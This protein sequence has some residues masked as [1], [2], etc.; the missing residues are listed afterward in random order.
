MNC[1]K[2]NCL[3]NFVENKVNDSLASVCVKVNLILFKV[4]NPFLATIAAKRFDT[5]I[6]FRRTNENTQVQNL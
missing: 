6:H 3:A 5:R 4:K 2:T 1:H